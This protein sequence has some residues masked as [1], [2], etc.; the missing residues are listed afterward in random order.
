[1]DNDIK[2]TL[3]ICLRSVKPLWFMHQT[4]LCCN[5]IYLYVSF[6]KYNVVKYVIYITNGKLGVNHTK[7]PREFPLP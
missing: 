4:R 7:V 6:M 3:S 2:E 5:S 1:M